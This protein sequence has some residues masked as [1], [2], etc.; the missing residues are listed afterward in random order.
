MAK[1]TQTTQQFKKFLAARREHDTEAQIAE[2][3]R[4]VRS[5]EGVDSR[6]AFSQ[7]KKRIQK[8][9]SRI[10]FLN[11]L[12]RAAAVLFV[13]LLIISVLVF[14][15][16]G[17]RHGKEQFATQ[18]IANPSGI[19]SEIG[20]PDGTKVWLNAESSIEYNVPFG[21]KKRDV[22][23]TGEAFFEVQK[24]EQK[25][26]QVKSGKVTVTVLGTC[27]NCSAFSEDKAIEVVLAEGKV[28][29]NTN[30]SETNKEFILKPGQRAVVD[31]MT[32]QTNISS[33][34]IEKYIGWHEGK[35][36]FD[37]CPLQEVARR[38]E[39]WFGIEV[40][41]ADPEIGDYKISTTFENES[42]RQI[43]IML[44]LASPIKTGIIP[45]RV[46]KTRQIQTKERVIITGKN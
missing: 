33:G 25:P 9:H 35:L 39:R 31:K 15:K 16:Q 6:K 4:I 45:T 12:T 1:D 38:L 34:N 14:Y 10:P 42:L 29:L 32:D 17:V 37:E 27:F 30:G 18:K 8:T 11:I 41:I 7:V 21:L 40:E 19:R 28:K 23:L 22:K 43:L 24:D 20:L 44:E 36:I 5:I 46:D 3:E 2:A 13:P 26:F